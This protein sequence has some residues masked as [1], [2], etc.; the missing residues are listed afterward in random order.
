MMKSMFQ[1]VWLV[2]GKG[3]PP[4]PDNQTN[5]TKAHGG[6]GRYQPNIRRIG[7]EMTAEWKQVNED[8]QEKKI[9][10][11]ADRVHEIFRHI[12]D[13]DC[14]ILK[15]DPEFARTACFKLIGEKSGK[16]CAYKQCHEIAL[17]FFCNSVIIT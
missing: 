9:V 15:M 1:E 2:K 7:L 11:T 16:E 10:L 13:E 8:T 6:C 14:S 17:K 5:P 4:Q 3:K 12:S